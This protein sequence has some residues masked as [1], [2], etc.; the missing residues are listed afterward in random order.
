MNGRLFRPTPQQA[1]V[2]RHADSAFITAC[3]GAG[4]T[5]VMAERARY[6]LKPGPD[7]RG[8]SF[9]SF[10]RAA[11]SELEIR[12]R[13]MALLGP[14]VFPHFVGTFDSFIWQFLVAPFGIPE[15]EAAP[16]LVPDKASRL[17]QPFDQAQP[18]PLSCFDRVSGSINAATALQEKSS[19]NKGGGN[20]CTEDVRQIPGTRRA[21]F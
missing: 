6:I 15:T 12:L 16:R 20:V 21:G 13:Q 9:L 4:K 7:S 11:V 5:C 18:L 17:I 3:P 1:Q 8:I 19:A 10:T 14:G 2:V